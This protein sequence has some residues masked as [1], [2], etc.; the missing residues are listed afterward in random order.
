MIHLFQN[1]TTLKSTINDMRDKKRQAKRYRLHYKIRKQGF[2][3]NT[4]EQ[5]IFMCADTQPSK[6][7]RVL[8]NEF[9]YTIQFNINYIEEIKN[10]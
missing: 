1:I 7:V 2:T 5:T 10:K 3:L 9:D 4:K 8:K 6:Q